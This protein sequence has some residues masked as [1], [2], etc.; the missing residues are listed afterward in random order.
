MI[1]FFDGHNDLLLK[2]TLRG[3]TAEDVRD[4]H[5]KGQID[6]PRAR[7]GGLGGGFFALF[8]PTPGAPGAP[9]KRVLFFGSLA[10]CGICRILPVASAWAIT[11]AS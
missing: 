7:A 3:L 10:V 4:G 2:M 11:P 1:P 9:V 5:G 8:V 6:V